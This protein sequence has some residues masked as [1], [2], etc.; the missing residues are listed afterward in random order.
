MNLLTNPLTHAQIMELLS[1]TLRLNNNIIV[2]A[3]IEVW[4]VNDVI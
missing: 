3:G 1:Q 2:V 4:G